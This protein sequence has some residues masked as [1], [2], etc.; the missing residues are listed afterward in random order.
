MRFFS[1]TIVK[2]GLRDFFDNEKGWLWGDSKTGRA[3]MSPELRQK[4]FEDLH[5]LWY[6]LLIR[7]VCLKERNKLLSHKHEC[8]RFEVFFA[9]EEQIRQTALTMSRIKQVLWERKLEYEKAQNALKNATTPAT[10][11][12]INDGENTIL[13]T[14]FN[15]RKNSKSTSKNGRKNKRTSKN[16]KNGCK[17]TSKNSSKSTS[18][19]P[20]KNV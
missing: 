4:S 14:T 8:K 12:T 2:R 19:N 17:S 1:T 6:L 20:I 9:N 11:D 18:K 7:Y 10:L 3:W 15:T 5:S 13:N 16:S